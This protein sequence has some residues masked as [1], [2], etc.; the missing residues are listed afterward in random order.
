[1][2]RPKTSL[3]RRILV[4]TDCAFWCIHDHVGV[5]AYLALPTL[6]ALVIGA[7]VLVGIWRTWDFPVAGRF[8]DC[9][10]AGPIPAAF[11]LHRATAA[12]RGLRLENRWWRAGHGRRMLRLVLAP[13][14]QAA[15]SFC[16]PGPALARFAPLVRPPAPRYLAADL[17]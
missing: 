6:A 5:I 16:P 12:L 14:G 17:P 11:H 2:A 8:L 4:Q 10:W 3:L 7:L 1:M 15:G 9:G 13:Q